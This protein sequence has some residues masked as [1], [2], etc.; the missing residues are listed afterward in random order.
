V[1]VQQL[2]NSN[3]TKQVNKGRDVCCFL[4]PV[5]KHETHEH[6]QTVAMYGDV[7]SNQHM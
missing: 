2:E 7:M 6:Q 4:I 5:G 3:P 1:L